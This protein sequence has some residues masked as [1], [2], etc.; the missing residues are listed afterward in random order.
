MD[1]TP[2]DRPESIPTVFVEAWNARDP[3][4]IA[5]LFDEDAEF[6]NVVGLWWHDR[7][8]IRRAHAYGLSRIFDRSTLRLGVV[9]VKRLV[10]GVAVVHA[11]M[12]LEDQTPVGAV[13]R[14]R[15]R[16]NIFSFVVHRT[17]DGWRCASAHNT[18][19]VPGME[20]NVVDEHGRLGAVD[21]RRAE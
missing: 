8:A 20:T 11:R 9:T 7:E 19:V 5:S 14:P 1:Y 4:T 17:A 21:Y 13:A 6:V 3:D 18:D 12:H 16:T 10:D 2:L 15:A